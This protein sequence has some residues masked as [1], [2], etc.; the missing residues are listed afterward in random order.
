MALAY[1]KLQANHWTSR[2]SKQIHVAG[3]KRGKTCLNESR[4]DYLRLD[5][6]VLR[7]FFK[8]VVLV[9]QHSV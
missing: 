1:Q 9:L 7:F 8:P 5:D 6:K 3:A 4:L 2:N